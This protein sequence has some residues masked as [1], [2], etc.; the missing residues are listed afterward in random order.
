MLVMVEKAPGVFT[1]RLVANEEVL[2]DIKKQGALDNFL[3]DAA[4]L[5]ADFRRRFDDQVPPRFN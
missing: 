1:L 2:S 3:A 4:Q 5:Y